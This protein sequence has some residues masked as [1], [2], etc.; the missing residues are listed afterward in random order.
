MIRDRRVSGRDS[1]RA[2]ILTFPPT[3]R[4][5]NRSNSFVVQ[6]YAG[7]RKFHQK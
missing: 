3:A 7:G 1:I 5:L 4:K 6:T 2:D